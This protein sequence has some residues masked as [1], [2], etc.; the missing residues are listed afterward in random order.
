MNLLASATKQLEGSAAH[1]NR[2]ACWLA[3]SA[4]EDV[5][6]DLLSL[7]GVVPGPRAS[8]RAKLS[9]LEVAY[10]DEPDVTARAQYAWLRL[11][12]ACHQHA[13]ELSPTH[14]EA[15]HL[16]ALVTDLADHSVSVRTS[17][18]SQG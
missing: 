6:D 3:R 17:A 11:S 4:L 18:D 16:V 5:I 8:G 2:R 7:K 9:C 13:Y 10:T 12:D 15:Q 1:S 14:S